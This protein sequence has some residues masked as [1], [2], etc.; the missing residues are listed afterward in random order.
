M[1]D[2]GGPWLVTGANGLLTSAVARELHRGG[3]PLLLHVHERTHRIGDLLAAH[4]SLAADL[5][6]RPSRRAFLREVLRRP[7][8]GG[9]VLGASR[10]EPAPLGS[11][12]PGKPAGILERELVSHLELV[13]G[14]AS[15]LEDGARIVLFSDA[16]TVLGWPSFGAYLAAKAGLEAAARSLA[17]AL[18]PRVV[19]FS[20]APGSLEGS[21]PPPD[22][23][24]RHRTAL[25]RSGTADEVARAVVGYCAL[26]PTVTQGT[27]LVVDGGRRLYP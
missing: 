27:C 24:V 3:C 10:F 13:H 1:R 4:P 7:P 25:G 19:V 5:A 18:G 11:G 6:A 12:D 20:V 23:T 16:G 17:R 22:A 9:L 8:L 2:P 15:Q 21:P 14:L 26:P